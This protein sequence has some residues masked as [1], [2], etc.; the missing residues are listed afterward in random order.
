MKFHINLWHQ[1]HT[2]SYAKVPVRDVEM[3]KKSTDGP[4]SR[5]SCIPRL[6]ESPHMQKWNEFKQKMEER[7]KVVDQPVG[8]LGFKKEKIE[9]DQSWQRSRNINNL[10][11]SKK[12]D[13]DN[14]LVEG[15]QIKSDKNNTTLLK[16]D[17]Q[18]KKG[19]ELYRYAKEKIAQM[20]SEYAI[21]K[22]SYDGVKVEEDEYNEKEEDLMRLK[23]DLC[24]EKTLKEEA[25]KKENSLKEELE[26]LKNEYYPM[27]EYFR[28]MQEDT[29][30]SFWKNGK[31]SEERK[32]FK[33]LKEDLEMY[34]L[35]NEKLE[36][37]Y[38]QLSTELQKKQNELAV[39]K[40]EANKN[41]K[42]RQDEIER[43]LQEKESYKADH[44]TLQVK[45]GM[46]ENEYG[47]FKAGLLGKDMQNETG[48][49]R[50]KESKKE[51]V[52]QA[53]EM[54]VMKI[55]QLEQAIENNDQLAKEEQ[56]R[57]NNKCITL[58]SDKEILLIKIAEQIN[59]IASKENEMKELIKENKQL[60]TSF[61]KNVQSNEVQENVNKLMNENKSL[62]REIQQQDDKESLM[63]NQIQ[64]LKIEL[65]KKIEKARVMK[66]KCLEQVE[67][68]TKQKTVT[69]CLEKQLSSLKME[70]ENFKQMPQHCEENEGFKATIEGLKN[71]IKL[72]AGKNEGLKEALQAKESVIYEM[73][74]EKQGNVVLK[75]ENSDLSK[76]IAQLYKELE[77]GKKDWEEKQAE[78][79]K[80]LQAGEKLEELLKNKSSMLDN[81]QAKYEMMKNDLNIKNNDLG[82]KEKDLD[83][84]QTQYEQLK[85]KLD[86]FQEDKAK[87]Q[88]NY[89]E[90]KDALKIKEEEFTEMETN[91]KENQEMSE[92]KIKVLQEEA[93]Q[94]K[95]EEE[96]LQRGMC[97]EK[98]R[99]EEANEELVE[100][101][102][103]I[104]HMKEQEKKIQRHA[105]ELKSKLDKEEE[106]VKALSRRN[107]ELEIEI[108]KK[109]EEQMTPNSDE[110]C[111]KEAEKLK[112]NLR[113][114]TNDLKE[115]RA[116]IMAYELE[117]KDNKEEI[118]EH[119]KENEYLKKKNE[120][121]Q[122]LTTMMEEA[123]SEAKKSK[124]S[125]EEMKDENV[126]LMRDLSKLRIK[127]TNLEEQ[128]EVMKNE[129][130]EFQEEKEM[131]ENVL[132]EKNEKIF[133]L[134]QA[135]RD[136]QIAYQDMDKLVAEKSRVEKKYKD[137]MFEIK[138]NKNKQEQLK[139]N[140]R[141]K[142]QY[143]ESDIEED[144]NEN[145]SQCSSEIKVESESRSKIDEEVKIDINET[146]NGK[147]EKAEYSMRIINTKEIKKKSSGNFDTA[148]EK[149][150]EMLHS[151]KPTNHHD[152]NDN[153][154]KRKD[155]ER[156][157]YEMSE[158]QS[159]F[160]KRK[161]S[162]IKATLQ[163]G[164]NANKLKNK[165]SLDEGIDLACTL[166]NGVEGNFSYQIND[167]CISSA[168]NETLSKESNKILLTSLG[169][170]HPV[171]RNT[172]DKNNIKQK[173]KGSKPKRAA[174]SDGSDNQ[175]C[176]SRQQSGLFA[177]SPLLARSAFGKMASLPP[178]N[179]RKN[180][181]QPLR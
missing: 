88:A 126:A 38:H 72:T 165:S 18:L 77:I 22:I 46:L 102:R 53:E 70:L 84:L 179:G 63:K 67:L 89:N 2:S 23:N 120:N 39:A 86:V 121:V 74:K 4:N 87:M 124:K 133:T 80:K 151:K 61:K 75:K 153:F 166:E 162:N 24:I 130:E 137:A 48:K 58:D 116:K 20:C 60:K 142:K 100:L 34:R 159:S 50:I 54:I 21:P 144:E 12:D 107:K 78:F 29:T 157:L 27:K 113:A 139:V 176:L 68:F 76:K 136:L 98:K 82:V 11:T 146:A 147:D 1:R 42:E 90:I 35:K 79:K 150:L 169:V 36:I 43:L 93:K 134:M 158:E 177:P 175:I 91:V 123:M 156:K 95:L 168:A 19:K 96:K 152:Q 28:K 47:R 31:Q 49:S 163:F 101:K 172:A 81:I 94:R 13:A 105:Y 10:L 25:R 7:V 140:E 17:Q 119:K 85:T 62:V 111:E 73:K 129:N 171:D 16:S 109:S 3:P 125:A 164:G 155:K 66:K 118:D 41:K 8:D 83:T 117:I 174:Q 178:L 92:K 127:I 26:A 160:G 181:L 99:K 40:E 145:T 59:E 14:D 112:E 52:K 149:F 30:I 128:I 15:K 173:K 115:V 132:E 110:R 33:E 114:T 37:A 32:K 170:G 71:E 148:K 65:K 45:I 143:H 135:E 167:V 57:L 108:K 131:L 9:D 64:T 97:E 5:K 154:I 122:E 69:T 138:S 44:A 6:V 161:A 104:D 55:R 106:F 141:R 51:Q 180:S 103:S 56:E